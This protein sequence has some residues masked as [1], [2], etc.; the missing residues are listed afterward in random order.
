MIVDNVI[1]N[2]KIEDNMIE[3]LRSLNK[4][5]LD[6]FRTDSTCTQTKLDDLE[7]YITQGTSYINSYRGRLPKPEWNGELETYEYNE[8]CPLGEDVTADL[9]GVL[10]IMKILAPLL[11]LVFSA[12]EAIVAITIHNSSINRFINAIIKCMG[13][14]WTLYI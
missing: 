5:E 10:R 3:L 7:G 13:F 8:K 1:F 14:I 12:Y 2:N 4:K 9:A 6:K 11:V